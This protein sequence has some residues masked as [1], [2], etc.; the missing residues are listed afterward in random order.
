VIKV[1]SQEELTTKIWRDGN[2]VAVIGPV[3]EFSKNVTYEMF[4]KQAARRPAAAL[5]DMASMPLRDDGDARRVYPS[6]DA[7]RALANHLRQHPFS[8]DGELLPNLKPQFGNYYLRYDL[9]K[10][11]DST[12]IALVHYDYKRN[13]IIVDFVLEIKPPK[14]GQIRLQA[15]ENLVYVLLARGFHIEKFSSDQWG[16]A[17]MQQNI[18]AKGVTT[19]LLSVDR[20]TQAHETLFDVVH[21][22]MLDFYDY[23]PLYSNMQTLFYVKNGKKIDHEGLQSAKDVIDGL[24]GAVLTCIQGEGISEIP[25]VVPL[26]AEETDPKKQLAAPKKEDNPYSDGDFDDFAL[27]HDVE[28][29]GEDE[30]E[31]PEEEGPTWV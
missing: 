1:P 31:T 28:V 21:S 16:S 8:P 25:E 6:I 20:T 17:Q 13:K 24:S 22:G 30:P 15:V 3:W 4:V 9:S 5:R 29:S 18:E 7:V 12:G 23:A 27:V 26:L 2:R 19:E 14:G 11:R 10:S